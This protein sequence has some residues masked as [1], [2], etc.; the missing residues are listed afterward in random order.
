LE[1][2][3]IAPPGLE[4]RGLTKRYGDFVAVDGVDLSVHPHEF[5][6]LLGPNGAGKSTMI[7]MVTG[8]LT[9]TQGTIHL[10]G[11]DLATDPVAAKRLLGLLPEDS[12]LLERLSGREYVQLVGRLHGLP[13]VDVRSR[14]EELFDLLELVERDRLIVDYSMGMKKKVGLAAALIHG[15]RI[16]FLDEPFNGMDV[17]TGRVVRRLLGQLVD[18]GLT[19]VFSSHVMEV[20]EK[21]C[22]RVGILQHGKLVALGTLEELKARAGGDRNLEELFLHYTG[23]AEEGGGEDLSWLS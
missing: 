14:C 19:I 16:L 1:G 10:H 15:P 4:V 12:S 20:V 8:L 2:E 9:P 3:L 22:T 13:E 17:I 21:L 5:F 7:K 18:K 6:A 23:H 11:V